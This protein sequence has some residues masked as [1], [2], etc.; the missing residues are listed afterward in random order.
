M[1]E[2]WVDHALDQARQAEGRPTATK[3]ARVEV[4]KKL[5]ETFAQ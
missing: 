5:K 4:G 3:K 2:E 1:A